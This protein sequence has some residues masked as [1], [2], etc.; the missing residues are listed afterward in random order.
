[1][2]TPKEVFD[3]TVVAFNAGDIEAA[4]NLASPEIELTAPGGLDFRGKEGLRQWF[5]L[6][7]DACP[8]RRVRYHN[9]VAQDDQVIGEGTFTGTHTGV[10]HLPS[11]DVPGTGRHVTASYAAVVRVA[12]QKITYMRHYFDVMDL[13]TQLGLIGAEART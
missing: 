4:W 1:M 12:D 8:D 9:V 3:K 13:M 6:W 2:L 7:S 5:Q 11:G 10:L